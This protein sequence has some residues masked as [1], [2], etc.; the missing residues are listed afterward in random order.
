MLDFVCLKKL[1]RM[2]SLPVRKKK[3]GF[4]LNDFGRLLDIARTYQE[5]V[6]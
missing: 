6:R 5:R 1:V 2:M 3:E 4:L